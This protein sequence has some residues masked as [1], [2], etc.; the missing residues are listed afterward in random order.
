MKYSEFEPGEMD[1]VSSIQLD[2]VA[3]SFEQKTPPLWLEI[4]ELN[5]ISLRCNPALESMADQSLADMAVAQVYRLISSMGGQNVY[6]P[7]G[8]TSVR[9]EKN[10]L[11]AK[12]FTGNN[13]RALAKKYRVSE[14]R[15]RQIIQDQANLKKASS[16]NK[17]SS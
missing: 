10:T 15:V 13:I 2:M 14:M 7:N 16:K 3:A 12:E 6:F 9:G 17:S 4:A 1:S 8:Y 5:F 11:I